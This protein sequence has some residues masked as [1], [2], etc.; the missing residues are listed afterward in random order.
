MGI[1]KTDSQSEELVLVDE[2][3][4]LVVCC[5]DSNRKVSHG[6]ENR[7]PVAQAAQSQFSDHKWMAKDL[8]L[9]EEADKF[10]VATTKVVN[11]DGCVDQNHWPGSAWRRDTFSRLGSLPPS[12]AR[13]RALSR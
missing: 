7:C 3:H 6:I 5:D 2:S 4:D 13:R 11:P 8:A 10:F 12:K 1:D 9:I